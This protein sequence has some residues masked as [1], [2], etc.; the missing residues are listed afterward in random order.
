MG[1]EITLEIAGMTLDWCKN[2]KG[3]DHGALFQNRD[4]KRIRS[5]QIN[6]EY[7]EENNED[8]ASMEMGFSRK[9]KDIVSRLDLLGFTLERARQEYLSAVELCREEERDYDDRDKVTPQDIMNFE[10]FC[11]FVAAY[12]I[13]ALD[14]TYDSK[15]NEE[16]VMRQFPGNAATQRLPQSSL[17]DK[18]RCGC[19][20]V[21]FCLWGS[22]GGPPGQY[23]NTLN[24][25]FAEQKRE[26]T[27]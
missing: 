21:G 19:V 24:P 26:E 16:Q 23:Q 2:S 9:L 20:V 1:T 11:A 8:P 6:Y 14:D 22:L 7:F 5:D 15:K 17:C 3:A 25:T 4:R 18:V 13:E 12:P 10:E 27:L